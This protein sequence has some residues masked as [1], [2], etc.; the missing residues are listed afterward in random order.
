MK[1]SKFK[2][3]HGKFTGLDDYYIELCTI[4]NRLIIEDFVTIA[5]NYDIN[6]ITNAIDCGIRPYLI[7]NGQN[8]EI[9]Y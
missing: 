6:T 1:I 7:K 2:F 8:W 3:F 5:R 4:D 9:R